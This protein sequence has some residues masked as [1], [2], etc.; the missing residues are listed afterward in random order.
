M[1]V[2]RVRE[3]GGKHVEVRLVGDYFDEAQKAAK[4]Y[5]K[6]NRATFVHPFN[7]RDV[8]V[9]QSTVTAEMLQ[10][11]PNIR[12]LIYPVG[13]GGLLAGGIMARDAFGSSATIIGAEP[14]GAASMT[15]A[16]AR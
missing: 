10:E 2:R 14:D 1:K 12:Q 15:Y 5:Q 8:I 9:G 7:D 16:L 4:I 13:G 11:N 3:F 6:E